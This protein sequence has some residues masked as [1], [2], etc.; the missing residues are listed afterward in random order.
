LFDPREFRRTSHEIPV[1]SVIHVTAVVIV[2][3]LI[4]YAALTS[5]YTVD[6]ASEGI[7]LRFGKFHA[8]TPPG[9]HFK[10]PFGID[11]TIVVP[12]R[13][14][15]TVE[16]GFE[17]VRPGRRTTYRTPP[18]GKE[19]SLMLTGDLNCA[20]LEWIVQYRIKSPQEYLFNVELVEDTIRDASESVIRTLVGDRS[21]DEVITT[22]RE[23]LG[24][25]A[26]KS[27]QELLDKYGC[28]VEIVTLKLQNATPPEEVRDAFDAVNRARQEKDEVINKAEGERN[29]E[30]PAARGKRDRQIA[31]AEGYA[32]KIIKEARGET[33]A[34]LAQLAE[35]E[36]AKE[37]TRARLF[38]E[39]MQEVL[40][41]CS[42]K[43][44]VDEK[45]KGILPILDLSEKG[46][47]K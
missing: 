7:V 2:L 47:K 15:E 3:I 30:I 1:A 25:E 41:N 40:S 33:S 18:G 11:T 45:L 35:Y 42:R 8:T 27:L 6:A 17:T 13:K 38:I 29:R 34:Y 31:E 43:V 14:V 4:L 12:T 22:G 9:L 10:L 36:K 23:E 39:A 28:G 21:V 44:I 26:K 20:M 5:V 24:F 32:E 19:V 16:F 37:V 46:G